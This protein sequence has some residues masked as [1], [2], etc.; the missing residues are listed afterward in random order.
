MTVDHFAVAAD[1][2]RDFEPKLSDTAA[3]AIHGGIVLPRVAS[4][5]D[6]LVN[7]PG[8]HLHQY[9]RRDHHALFLSKLVSHTNPLRC[10]KATGSS[11][12]PVL[13]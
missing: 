8:M 11:R 12:I 7:R 2:T 3:H 9:G 10:P 4:V 13:T 5:K 6:Q 1:Q